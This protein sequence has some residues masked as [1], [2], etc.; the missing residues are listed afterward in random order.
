[1]VQNKL[2]D[3]KN[4]IE[5]SKLKEPWKTI[6]VFPHHGINVPLF[7]IHSN[8]SCGIGEFLD[9]KLLID[10]CKL[11][12][13]DIIQLLPLNDTGYE[14]S[15]Y[16]GLSSKA[17]NPIYLSICDLPFV[18]ND[19]ELK[20]HLFTFEKYKHLQK[21]P[22]IAIL[23]QKLKFMEV[24][25]NKYFEVFEKSDG[26]KSFINQN[27]WVREYGLFKTLKEEY[28]HK[29]WLFWKNEDKNITHSQAKKLYKE[30]Q[31]RINFYIFL[32]FL[33][34]SQLCDVKDYAS[35]K[36]IFL[37]GD[38]PILISLESLDV[39][40]DRENFNLNYS[41]GAA[42]D[43][44]TKNGQNWGFPIYNWDHIESTGYLFWKDRLKIAASFYHLFRIDHIHGLY[45]IFAI[46]R[47]KKAKYGSLDPSNRSLALLQGEVII[48]MLTSFT[49]ML[50]IGEDLGI[51]IEDIRKSLGE[52]TVPTTKI[53]RWEKHHF[54]DGSFI[55]Y[56]EYNPLSLTTVSTHDSQTLTL[57][58]NK[59]PK[60]VKEFARA[61]GICYTRFLNNSNRY[62]MLKQSHQSSS[63]FHINLLSEYLALFD[64]LVWDNP[65]D[66]RINIPGV[67]LPSNW[68]YKTRVSLE[69][70]LNH[71]A[72]KKAIKSIV[73]R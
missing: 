40:A 12:D 50:P 20:I 22:Y 53:P 68:C 67:V 62:Q 16:N 51:D 35:K 59:N 2:E 66:E 17:L 56:D 42:P 52:K 58:W 70:L 9:L 10:F 71:N 64:D 4:K 5:K 46:P 30:K 44:L 13:M 28:A 61:M 27:S 43:M 34:F 41:A 8:K 18:K 45:R 48:D 26:Y 7:S 31:T 69:K 36:G 32:Q 24:Y 72:L 37:K 23:T 15:P 6:G 57:W 11:V 39:W 29:D 60:E 21:I 19:Q 55:P 65:E 1:M 54:T 49:K 38:I 73:K 25:Y 63:L 47:G 33:S 14:S 3:I